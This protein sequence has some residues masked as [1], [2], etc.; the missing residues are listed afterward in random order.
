MLRMQACVVAGAAAAG[1]LLPLPPSPSPP[2][3]RSG[4]GDLPL[5]RARFPLLSS[6]PRPPQPQGGLRLQEAFGGAHS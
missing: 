6:L 4:D 2:A 1:T 5:N 3:S